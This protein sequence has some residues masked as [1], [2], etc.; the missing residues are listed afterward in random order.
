MSG[1]QALCKP[2]RASLVHSFRDSTQRL[3][4]AI[5]IDEDLLDRVLCFRVVQFEEDG[6]DNIEFRQYRS[7]AWLLSLLSRF[8]ACSPTAPSNLKANID[9]LDDDVAIS[10]THIQRDIVEDTQNANYRQYAECRLA[11]VQHRRC[12]VLV[13]SHEYGRWERLLLW[14]WREMNEHWNKVRLEFWSDHK[15]VTKEVDWVDVNRRG[16][17]DL[18][19]PAL[20]AMDM[21]LH[22]L[23]DDEA[24][25]A[26]EAAEHQHLQL[27]YLR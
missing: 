1:T 12:H 5:M 14:R 21:L 27:P 18:R 9:E 16:R 23:P 3:G 15:L 25:L 11:M 13:K 4:Q 10:L 2:R 22:G 7:Q 19:F 6:N 26:I 17:P 24:M 8:A 20:N